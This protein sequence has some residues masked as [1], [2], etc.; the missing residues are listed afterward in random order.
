MVNFL[1]GRLLPYTVAV[2]RTHWLSP[3]A[4]ELVVEKPGDFTFQAGQ[5]VL[6]EK[7]GVQREYSF[8]C[9]PLDAELHFC[10]RFL[11]DGALSAMLAKVRPGD[12]LN[13][14]EAYGFFV[15]RPGKAVFVA[16][17]TGIAPF[18]AYA[19][20]GVHGLLLL[21][22]VTSIED[23][24]YRQIVEKAVKQYVP[25]LSNEESD[26]VQ[27]AAGVAGRVTT[28]LA[29]NLDPGIYDFYLCGN[30]TMIGEATRIIDATSPDSRVFAESY[31]P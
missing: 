7:D 4:F 21:H 25:C 8:A 9:S 2:K 18:V 11:E 16:T 28:Y 31:F 24:Y 12:G 15:Y 20:S 30:G 17:G 13:I 22:G 19:K 29:E 10:I 1:G 23:L 3:N 26:R 5:K 14:S 27:A 6:I